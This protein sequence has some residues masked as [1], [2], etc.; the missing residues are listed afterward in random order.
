[1]LVIFVI[2]LQL[3]YNYCDFHPRKAI[4]VSLV[5][6][7]TNFHN[8]MNIQKCILCILRGIIGYIKIY[9]CVAYEEPYYMCIQRLLL[10]L[11]GT[12][13]KVT[14]GVY[15]EYTKVPCQTFI[16]Y[17]API[18]QVYPNYFIILSKIIT[19]NNYYFILSYLLLL[20][21]I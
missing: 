2:A 7:V 1:V 9:K 18:L 20:I 21:T 5:A 4:Y 17:I 11:N 14:L 15:L 16:K 10:A 12:N 19:S 6:N 13:I 8:I 3:V